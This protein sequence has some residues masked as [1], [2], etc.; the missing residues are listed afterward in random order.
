[1]VLM[2]RNFAIGLKN[3]AVRKM[4]TNSID[5]NR[6]FVILKI[7]EKNEIEEV[8]KNLSAIIIIINL[9]D[10]IIYLIWSK[11]IINEYKINVRQQELLLEF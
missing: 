11:K 9:F 5:L 6:I 3:P 8:V 7:C 2:N 1:M 4:Q 10:T